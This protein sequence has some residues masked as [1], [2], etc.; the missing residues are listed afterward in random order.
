MSHFDDRDAASLDTVVVP[1]HD[2]GFKRV[3]LKENRWYAVK[4]HPRRAPHLKYIA[5]YRAQPISAITHYA[6][7]RS[8]QPWLNSGKMVINFAEPASEIGPLKVVINGRVKPQQGLRYTSL[9]KLKRAHNLDE[10]Y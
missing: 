5:V 7:I 8:I 10:V 1:A 2:D 6:P 3:F 9:Q 4:I